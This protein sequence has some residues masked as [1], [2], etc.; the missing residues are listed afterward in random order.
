VSDFA[1]RTLEVDSFGRRRR[2]D[3]SSSN[4]AKSKS[5]RRRRHSP[6]PDGVDGEMMVVQ[7]ITISDRNGPRP[8]ANSEKQ[9]TKTSSDN[10]KHV[11]F[12]QQP[13][14]TVETNFVELR[15]DGE[16]VTVLTEASAGTFQHGYCVNMVGLVVA[17]SLFLVAQLVVI[18]AW[19]YVWQKKRRAKQMDDGGCP[20]PEAT[21]DSL[22]QLFNAG[23]PARRF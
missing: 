3:V 15:E 2:R 19:T 10:K 14:H 4:S 1:G 5:S 16:A 7:S 20:L 23:Y 12:Q 21:A 18:V 22:T 17:C 13:G 6:Y 11:R 8:P 9:K